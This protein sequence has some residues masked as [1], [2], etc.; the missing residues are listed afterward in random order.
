MK[1]TAILFLTLIL[2]NFSSIYAQK[3]VIPKL[4][5]QVT[6]LTE[7][8]TQEE[9]QLLEQ[10]LKIFEDSVGSQVVVLIISTTG[11]ENIEEYSMRVAKQWKI[12]R[13]K[14]DDGVILLIAKNDRT[15]RIEVGYGIEAIIT[16]AYA[17]RIINEYIVPQFKNGYFYDGINDGVQE[18]INLINGNSTLTVEFAVIIDNYYSEIKDEIKE[19]QTLSDKYPTLIM[20]LMI[21]S[22]I[23]P[24]VFFLLIRKKFYWSLI[25]LILLISLNFFIGYAHGSYIMTW[26]ILPTTLIIGI[27]VLIA[28]AFPKTFSGG[29]GS[30]SSSGS[31]GGSSYRSTSSGGSSYGGS[32]SYGGGSSYSG[33]G[34]SFGGGGASGGW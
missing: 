34:G 30:Y 3:E 23:A 19:H 5:R 14:A 17:N 24:C 7:T 21:F 29:G 16:D 27:M 10:K 2:I 26:A 25:L 9:I 32:S 18:I 13:K 1:K 22:F 31:Y 20:I 33:G 4:N 8:L 6:D 15:L 12:G 11:E 28:T